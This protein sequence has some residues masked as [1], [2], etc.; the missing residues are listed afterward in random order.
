MFARIMAV[1]MAAIL[2]TTIGLS[3]VWWIT[4]RN[5]QIDARLDHLSSEAEEIAYLAGKLSGDSLMDTRWDRDSVAREYLNRIA[6]K[7]SE[8][9]N[10]LIVVM[11][12]DG[13]MVH[14][15]AAG[16]DDPEFMESLNSEETE[17]ALQRIRAGEMRCT[18]ASRL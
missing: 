9:Y 2:V 14:N 15:Q 12:Q 1:V 6:N 7:V 4:L 11:D 17:M 13:I 8:E 16:K 3:A 5:Q 10:A 18:T